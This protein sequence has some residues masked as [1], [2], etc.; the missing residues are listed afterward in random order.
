MCE[1]CQD[2]FSTEMQILANMLTLFVFYFVIMWKILSCNYVEIDKYNFLTKSELTKKRSSAIYN[3]NLMMYYL[4][5]N[6]MT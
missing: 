6:I 4:K 2:E 1:T 3:F 5:T